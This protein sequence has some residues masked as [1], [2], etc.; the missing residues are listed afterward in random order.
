MLCI[1][2]VFSFFF[3]FFKQKTAYE[4]SVSDWS[5]D[6]CSSDL[7]VPGAVELEGLRRRLEVSA[8]TRRERQVA[9]RQCLVAQRLDGPALLR[10]YPGDGGA[11]DGDLVA[12]GHAVGDLD[13]AQQL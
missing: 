10:A 5:S 7:T 8:G 4:M 12:G 9:V 11:E 2:G 1:C 6:V 13:R 3:F